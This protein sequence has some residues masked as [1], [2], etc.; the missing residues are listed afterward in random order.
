MNL[1]SII[2]SL[3]EKGSQSLLSQGDQNCKIEVVDLFSEKWIFSQTEYYNSK[4]D[5]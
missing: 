3:R 2:T 1:G 4:V 5:F